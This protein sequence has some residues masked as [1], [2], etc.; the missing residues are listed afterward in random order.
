MHK[1]IKE[2]KSNPERPNC[3]HIWLFG[4]FYFNFMYSMYDMYVC[5]CFFWLI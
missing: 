3:L 5:M 2:E 1:C 4:I